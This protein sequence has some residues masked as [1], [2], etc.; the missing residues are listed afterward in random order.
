MNLPIEQ[1]PRSRRHRLLPWGSREEPQGAEVNQ[2]LQ[3]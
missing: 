1:N 3:G 2:W